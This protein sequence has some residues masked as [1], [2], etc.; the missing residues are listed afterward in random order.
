[1]ASIY[2]VLVVVVLLCCVVLEEEKLMVLMHKWKKVL[3]PTLFSWWTRET[4][5]SVR[6]SLK[7]KLFTTNFLLDVKSSFSSLFY[8]ST[9]QLR[10]FLPCQ[11]QL[12]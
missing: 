5:F 6:L 9:F 4:Y 2:I 3:L 10:R 11:W 7:Q 12:K 8:F 1:M